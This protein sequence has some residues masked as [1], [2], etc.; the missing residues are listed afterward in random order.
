MIISPRRLKLPACSLPLLLLTLAAA[1]LSTPAAQA[2]TADGWQWNATTVDGTGYLP[3]EDL[4]SFYKF[5]TSRQNAKA[6]T[7]T[8][9]NGSTTLVFGPEA[10]SLT[11]NGFCCQLTHPV[12][13]DERGN[14]L[15]SKV[16]MV[17][18]IDPILR[19]TY[20]ANR[21]EVKAVVID[22]GHGGHDV[23]QQTPQLREAD[24][25]LA[26]AHQLAAELRKRGYEV[27]LTREDNQYLSDQQRIDR[28]NAVP[29]ALFVS[30]HANGFFND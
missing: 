7:H 3:L 24:C 6:G 11:L 13:L 19:P 26:L 2:A 30:L 27:V 29:N 28:A 17:K 23:G 12:K 1:A 9:S 21:R 20:I 5:T 4:R 22:P 14:M 15:V 8:I 10:R 16:D 25:T 18:L